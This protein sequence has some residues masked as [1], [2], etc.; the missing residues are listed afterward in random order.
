MQKI[1]MASLL[2]HFGFET[3]LRSRTGV[4]TGVKSQLDQ[5]TKVNTAAYTAVMAPPSVLAEL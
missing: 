2:V 3:L 4:G 1:A 5:K